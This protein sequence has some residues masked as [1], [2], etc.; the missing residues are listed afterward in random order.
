MFVNSAHRQ[1]PTMQPARRTP[2]PYIQIRALADLCEGLTCLKLPEEV[3]AQVRTLINPYLSRE[4]RMF[5]MPFVTA[6]AQETFGPD[7]PQ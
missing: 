2:P 3:V 7:R 1:E 5:L 6:D 4:T